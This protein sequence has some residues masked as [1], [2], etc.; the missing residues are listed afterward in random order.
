MPSYFSSRE[1]IVF[2]I[3]TPPMIS[4]FNPR[5]LPH[6][7]P[8]HLIQICQV[9]FIYHFLNLFQQLIQICQ[10]RFIR[11]C[12]KLS[13]N[14]SK[15][16][17][18]TPSADNSNIPSQMYSSLWTSAMTSKMKSREPYV[19][20][21]VSPSM[22]LFLNPSKVPSLIISEYGSGMTIHNV[23]SNMSSS[24][25][26]SDIS[27][28]S[29]RYNQVLKGSIFAW[30]SAVPSKMKAREPSVAHSVSPSI[31]LSVNPSKGPYLIPSADHSDMPSQIY[32]LLPRFLSAAHLDMT[33]KLYSS[34]PKQYPS[35]Q[36]NAP[37]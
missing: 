22:M 26:P 35:I 11:H 9:R 1:P 7:I 31:M 18:L 25:S 23:E 12:L 4:Y 8:Q 15:G 3:F 2:H 20:H 10:V 37:T 13:C 32:S 34:Q 14:T 24:S 27:L 16:L 28:L 19:S 29:N 36:V 33:S 5:K 17:H 6:L 30:P 21:S